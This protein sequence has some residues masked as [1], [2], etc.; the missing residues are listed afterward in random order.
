MNDRL[1]LQTQLSTKDT[2]PKIKTPSD[3]YRWGACFDYH[4][5]TGQI[6]ALIS[7]C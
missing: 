1:R 7:L 5:D 4:G 2:Q 6:D 3:C